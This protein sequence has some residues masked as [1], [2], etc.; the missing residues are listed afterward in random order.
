VK[1]LKYKDLVTEIQCMWNVK[2]NM[3]PVIWGETGTI[4]QSFRQYLVLTYWES[5]KSRNYKKRAILGT[6]HVLRKVLM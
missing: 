4:S 5:T 2:A 6:E 3:I 1:V